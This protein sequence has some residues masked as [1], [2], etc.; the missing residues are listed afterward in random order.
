MAVLLLEVV[1]FGLWLEIMGHPFPTSKNPLAIAYRDIM[2]D[3]C[4]LSHLHPKLNV[5]VRA[6]LVQAVFN[7]CFGLLYLGKLSVVKP[8]TLYTDKLKA[9][10]LLSMPISLAAR[11]SSIYHMPRPF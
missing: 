3:L 1:Y 6:I 5:P 8:S 7:L 10:K 9:R 2:T 4:S 11:S